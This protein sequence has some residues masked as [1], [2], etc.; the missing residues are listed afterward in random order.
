MKTDYQS[1][2]LEKMY[3]RE[4][5]DNFQQDYIVNR[6]NSKE[7]DIYNLYKDYKQPMKIVY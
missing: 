2:P 1:N 7:K 5:K 6:N 4:H 3:N